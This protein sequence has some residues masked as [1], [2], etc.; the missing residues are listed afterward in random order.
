[1][2]VFK[3]YC[4]VMLLFGPSF[5]FTY[6]EGRNGRCPGPLSQAPRSLALELAPGRKGVPLRVMAPHGT[7]ALVSS[8]LQHLQHLGVTASRR[9]ANRGQRQAGKQEDPEGL[10]V[11]AKEW[12][13]FSGPASQQESM[14]RCGGCLIASSFSSLS[15]VQFSK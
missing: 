14:V 8:Y 11:Q 3:I 1:M 9:E 12:G 2:S 7:E 13:A 10:E 4:S 5:T 6:T 15:E